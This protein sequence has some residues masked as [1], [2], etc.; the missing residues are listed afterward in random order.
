MRLC[1]GNEDQRHEQQEQH[2]DVGK[3]DKQNRLIYGALTDDCCDSARSESDSRCGGKWG[4][5][6]PTWHVAPNV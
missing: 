1:A 6:I 3:E 2:S 4:E 5:H